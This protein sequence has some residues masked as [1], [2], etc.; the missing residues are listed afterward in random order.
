MAS[1]SPRF[2]LFYR[3]YH[4]VESWNVFTRVHVYG[5][6]LTTVLAPGPQDLGLSAQ[7][8]QMPSNGLST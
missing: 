2:L 1:T 5:H 8:P 7:T 3:I 4:D 6:L